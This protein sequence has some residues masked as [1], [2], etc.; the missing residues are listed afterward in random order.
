MSFF[1]PALLIFCVSNSNGQENPPVP[2]EVEV[3]NAQFLNFG[4]FTV[5][6]GGGTVVVNPLSGRSKTG[7]VFLLGNEF[8]PAI[9]DVYANPGTIVHIQSFSNVYLNGPTNQTIFL[10]IQPQ[11]DISPGQTFVTSS[12]PFPVYVGGT[13]NIPSGNTAGAGSYN[14]TFSLT[15]IHQ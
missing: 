15:F 4:K 10:Q 3:R 2:I 9:F 1:L 11:I 5:G 14:A 6:A 13:L 7:D 12:S 8:S